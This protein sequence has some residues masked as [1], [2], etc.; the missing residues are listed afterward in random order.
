M[1]DDIFDYDNFEQI[2]LQFDDYEDRDKRFLP[3]NVCELIQA[4][5]LIGYYDPNLSGIQLILIISIIESLSMREKYKTFPRWYRDNREDQTN[6]KCLTSF[7]DY[8]EVHGTGKYFRNFF[9]NI[10]QEDKFDVLNKIYKNY[11]VETSAPFCYQ[12]RDE[13]FDPNVVWK[14]D[15]NGEMRRH[16]ISYPFSC[17]GK[18]SRHTCP[19]MND[20]KV[21]KNGIDSLSSHLQKMRNK[22]VHQSLLP[23]SFLFESPRIVDE[24]T[25]TIKISSSLYTLEK[26]DSDERD[27]FHSTLTPKYL[28]QLVTKYL[29]KLFLDYLNEV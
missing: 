24:K 5:K 28:Y 6:K 20:E 16:I 11:T 27:I 8:N 21:F 29:P 18:Y 26:E 2:C 23:S 25:R 1:V 15:D 4:S 14:K 7:Q 10:D 9:H 19:A 13:C 17:K 3:F 12:S 22:F